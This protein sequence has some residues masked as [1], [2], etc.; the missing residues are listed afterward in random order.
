MSE[1]E[2][3]RLRGWQSDKLEKEKV[4]EGEREEGER[5]RENE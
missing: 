4:F 3:E 5:L 1:S 2:R